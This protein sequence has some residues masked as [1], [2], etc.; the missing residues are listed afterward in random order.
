MSV[1]A[2]LAR[3]VCGTQV[4]TWS[5]DEQ[6]LLRRHAA[7]A[8]LAGLASA[9][10][11]EAAALRR[12][13]PARGD[14]ARITLAATIARTSEADDIHLASCT[15][16]S[17]VAAPVALMLAAADPRLRAADVADAIAVGVEL[18]VR[19]GLAIDGP[20]ALS[21]QVWPT[22]IAAPLGTAAVAARL[23][24][25]DEAKAAHAL[26]LALMLS[27]GRT[28][29][30]HGALSGR[31][32]VFLGAVAEGLR[33]ARAAAAG[34]CGDASLLDGPWPAKAQG[35]TFDAS[36]LTDGLGARSV[37]P[38]LSLKPFGAAR[39]ALGAADAFIAL[40]DEG[41]D[42]DGVEA[43]V[44]R[45]PAAH[46]A[47]IAEGV[48]PAQRMTGFV[49]A[50]FLMGLAAYRRDDLWDLDRAAAMRDARILALARRTSV[51]ADASL[52]AEYP[53]RWSAA[54]AVTADGRTIERVASAVIGDPDRPLGD[55]AVADK[56]AR[57]LASAMEEAPA[58]AIV[59]LAQQAFDDDD[60][61]RAF[62][63]LFH[64]AMTA[65]E[66]P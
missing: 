47:M 52:E 53:R 24:R 48:D 20:R 3:F 42:P 32:V 11:R 62:A 56:A 26:S 44:V 37:F 65:A 46:A 27:A 14:D 61:C 59:A 1:I 39:Q 49:N 31:W 6:A 58:Q 10:T 33:A 38:A 25:L 21:R 45:V 8:A 19:F 28:G 35:L 43:I 30:F 41:L 7:D 51:V 13:D 66:T 40:L 16:P 18:V 15:T 29:R 22:A 64:N 63:V 55:A 4:S 9:R 60:A 5:A 34:Y 17:S 57:L 23:W 12:I 54:I 36:A 50:G 2:D